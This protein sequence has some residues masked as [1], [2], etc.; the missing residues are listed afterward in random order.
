MPSRP[1]DTWSPIASRHGAVR[2]AGPRLHYLSQRRRDRRFSR[3]R[4][5]PRGEAAGDV[6][7]RHPTATGSTELRLGLPG[8]GGGGGGGEGDTTKNS[9]KRAFEETVDL[10][11]KLQTTV[12][13][14]E[15]AP[16]KMKRSPSHKNVA[17]SATD[18]A[19]PPAP[20]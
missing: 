13:V 16:E 6:I 14:E 15:V 11:L 4:A 10:K 17:A 2:H 5:L 3:R 8:A 1:S 7:V 12:D 19:R 9:G 18:P 20:K